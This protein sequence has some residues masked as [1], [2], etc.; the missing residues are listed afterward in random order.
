[1][2]VSTALTWYF[3]ILPMR[4]S[5]SAQ[6]HI[7][8]GWYVCSACKQHTEERGSETV[9]FAYVDEAIWRCDIID[10]QYLVQFSLTRL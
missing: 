2:S 10:K 7:V 5:A 3:A 8:D 4:L 6:Q 1:M 9:A